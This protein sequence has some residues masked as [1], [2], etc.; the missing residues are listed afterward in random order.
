MCRTGAHTTAQDRSAVDGAFDG[1][2]ASGNARP[3]A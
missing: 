2:I 3:D 1:S